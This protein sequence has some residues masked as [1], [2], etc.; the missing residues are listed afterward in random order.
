[1]VALPREV[2]S[3]AQHMV[4]LPRGVDNVA[5]YMVALPT[6]EEYTV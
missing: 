5:Q 1:M 4:A 2:D 6:K 3:V